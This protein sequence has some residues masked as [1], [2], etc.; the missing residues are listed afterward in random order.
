M[1][2]YYDQLNF[3]IEV[4][5]NKDPYTVANERDHTKLENIKNE[6]DQLNEEMG[7]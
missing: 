2:T 5:S 7:P 3:E 4:L 1:K 6:F